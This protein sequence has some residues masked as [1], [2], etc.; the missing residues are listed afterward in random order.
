[1]KHNTIALLAL[2]GMMLF[3][4]SCRS[5]SAPAKAESA[6]TV[7]TVP[8]IKAAPGM[9]NMLVNVILDDK[10]D[11]RYAHRSGTTNMIRPEYFFKRTIDLARYTTEYLQNAKLFKQVKMNTVN[12]KGTYTLKLEWLS[13]NV[14]IN[15][16]IP[17]V[18]RIQT[19]MTVNMLL[20][21]P[22]GKVIWNHTLS[23][24]VVNTPSSFR[25]MPGLPCKTYQENV[26][27]NT[28]P[29]ALSDLCHKLASNPALLK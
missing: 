1:M 24:H 13:S 21:T 25:Y 22:A 27:K 17:F 15:T 11:P 3:T 28:L 5:H 16:W 26:M 18:T 10:R 9:N 4:A 6:A 20:I 7:A 19:Q 12:T 23:G 8:V 14:N 2:T 29:Y